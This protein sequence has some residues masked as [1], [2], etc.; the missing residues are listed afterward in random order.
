MPKLKVFQ[1]KV[2]APQEGIF[3]FTYHLRQTIFFIVGKAGEVREFKEQKRGGLERLWKNMEFFLSAEQ[4]WE[5]GCTVPTINACSYSEWFSS[6][7]FF[8]RDLLDADSPRRQ[9]FLDCTFNSMPT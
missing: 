3:D 5:K 6:P 9:N 7:P 1:G 2:T 8:K 4:I